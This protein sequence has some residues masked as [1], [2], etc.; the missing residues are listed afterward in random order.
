MI[1]AERKQTL[2]RSVNTDDGCFVLW[3]GAGFSGCG[4]LLALLW[5]GV[6]GG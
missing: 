6:L 3:T 5:G 1:S 2:L 4:L